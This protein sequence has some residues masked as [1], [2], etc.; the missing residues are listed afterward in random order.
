MA[1]NRRAMALVWVPM[2]TACQPD[3]DW[4]PSDGSWVHGP[5]MSTR[6]L[7]FGE[8]PSPSAATMR[9]ASRL[10]LPCMATELMPYGRPVGTT[11]GT[12]PQE[13]SEIAIWP[14]PSA[15]VDPTTWIVPSALIATPRG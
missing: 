6:T 2:A 15:V 1:A 14:W 7:T 12:V 11:R 5:V 4:R 13:V 8:T 9:I 10:L 3:P